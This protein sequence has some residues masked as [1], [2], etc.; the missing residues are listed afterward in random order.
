MNDLLP[1]GNRKVMQPAAT[2]L[3]EFFRGK[4][5]THEHSN[6]TKANYKIFQN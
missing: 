3:M 4:L 5:N 6:G 1:T 2:D